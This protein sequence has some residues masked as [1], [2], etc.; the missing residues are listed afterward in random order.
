[1]TTPSGQAVWEPLPGSHQW[2][3]IET[4]D[5]QHRLSISDV[6]ATVLA[7][8]Q[9]APIHSVSLTGGEPLLQ[10][11]FLQ[12]LLPVLKGYGLATY[13]ETSGT[14]PQLLKH[15]L[16]WLDYISM[17]I[18]LPSS[19]QQAAQW[20]QHRLF[21]EAA[22]AERPLQAIW[23]KCVVNHHTTTVELNELLGVVGTLRPLILLQ[24]ETP[25]H[26]GQTSLLTA[27]HLL[28]LEAF[29]HTLGFP[30]RVIPQTHKFLQLS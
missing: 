20:Q 9:Q 18:K 21:F 5:A 15:V 4:D 26:E 29:V 11:P 24:P 13:L 19:T 27:Q 22:A 10:T 2:Q 17:D 8:Q 14:Q 3:A 28:E 6:V 30:V 25:I 16:P 12:E 1:M 23:L 7:L